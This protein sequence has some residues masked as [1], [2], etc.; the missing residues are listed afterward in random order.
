MRDIKN[1]AKSR[2]LSANVRRLMRL[3]RE[4]PENPNVVKITRDFMERDIAY[5]DMQGNIFMAAL[6][7]D[8]P[9]SMFAPMY[10]NSQ[11]AG[12][13]DYSF[14][15]KDGLENDE[16]VQLLKIPLLLKSPETIVET[17][18]WIEHIVA[19]LNEEQ[20]ASA[21]IMSACLSDTPTLELS[22]A[23]TQLALP[24]AANTATLERPEAIAIDALADEYEYAYWLGYIYRCEC[25]L[26]DESSRMVYGAFSEEFMCKT[27]D[28]MLESGIREERL[29]ACAVEICRRLDMMLIGKLWKRGK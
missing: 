2:P 25:L 1:P 13:I 7:K 21:A 4:S 18:V 12:I 20:S 26:H 10:M 23:T 15:C 6:D 29:S 17:M 3:A 28:Q 16:T 19:N 14:S 5:C 22:A 24:E 8:I 11:I 27:Y 9:M